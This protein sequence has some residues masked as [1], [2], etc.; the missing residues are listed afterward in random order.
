MKRL[1]NGSRT[2]SFTNRCFE[3]HPLSGSSR[4]TG[5][6]ET[7]LGKSTYSLH[8][9]LVISISIS[10]LSPKSTYS[11]IWGSR[12]RS[13]FAETTV[14]WCS[15]SL[16]SKTLVRFSLSKMELTYLVGVA[17]FCL[18]LCLPMA[19]TTLPASVYFNFL[20][21]STNHNEGLL[22][23]DKMPRSLSWIRYIFRI[24]VC[25]LDALV[26]LPS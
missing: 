11:L 26:Y 17:D 8:P 13:S 19:V 15:A 6:S 5:C 10:A 2:I 20:A 4:I 9:R 18:R 3:R 24:V 1:K 23:T 16:E 21:Y 7:Y 22:E 12:A 25:F 14:S